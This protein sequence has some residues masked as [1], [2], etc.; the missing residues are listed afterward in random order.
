M[1]KDVRVL[2]QAHLAERADRLAGNGFGLDAY[3]AALRVL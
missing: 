2:A 1:R 3:P